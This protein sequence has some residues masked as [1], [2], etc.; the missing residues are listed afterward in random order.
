[1]RGDGLR[2][3]HVLHPRIL[4]AEDRVTIA[5]GSRCGGVGDHARACLVLLAASSTLG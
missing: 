4:L 3:E 2:A 5:A 1:V